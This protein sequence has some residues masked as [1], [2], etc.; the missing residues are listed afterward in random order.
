[1]AKFDLYR[2][3]D[4]IV[5]LDCQSDL[6]DHLNTRFVVPL[7]SPDDAVQV[8]RRLNPVLDVRGDEMLMLTHFAAAVPVKQLGVRI[9]SVV[10]QEWSISSALDVLISGF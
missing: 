7:A 1:M 5:L 10:E 3:K 9:G 6:L 2:V 4:G 8:D